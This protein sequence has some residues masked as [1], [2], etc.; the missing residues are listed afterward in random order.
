MMSENSLYFKKSTE[1]DLKPKNE[2]KWSLNVLSSASSFSI[3]GLLQNQALVSKMEF[4][5]TLL[6]TEAQNKKVFLLEKGIYLNKFLHWV[7][8]S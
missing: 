5:Y 6:K 7:F 4:K 8:F 3:S 1:E 2:K